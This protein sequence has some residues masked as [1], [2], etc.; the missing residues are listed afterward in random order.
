MKV[1]TCLLLLLCLNSFKGM[2]QETEIY[3]GSLRLEEVPAIFAEAK[4]VA[5]EKEWYI[6]FN[7]NQACE[8]PEA[9]SLY[10]CYG[11]KDEGGNMIKYKNKVHLFNL[12]GKHGW[13]F[14][15]AIIEVTGFEGNVSTR[16]NFIFENRNIAS[17]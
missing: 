1:I 2:S 12:L 11:L 5:F 13:F 8:G 17:P 4:P 14:K 3:V 7:S 9:F 6:S 16:T 10:N 15:E